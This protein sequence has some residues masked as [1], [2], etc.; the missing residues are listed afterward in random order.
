M[1]RIR[2]AVALFLL[3]RVLVLAYAGTGRDAQPVIQA[4]VDLSGGGECDYLP[5]PR[6]VY[7]LNGSV[8]FQQRRAI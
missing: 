7:R 6:G 3:R 1:K 2:I 4:I 8:V 5:L